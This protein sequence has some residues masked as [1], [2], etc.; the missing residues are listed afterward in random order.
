MQY[1]YNIFAKEMGFLCDEAV[2][3]QPFCLWF[4][5]SVDNITFRILETPGSNDQGIAFP[6]PDPFLHLSFDSAQAGDPVSTLDTDVICP[7][8]HFG[9]GELLS[10]PFF[11]EP[12][13]NGWRTIFINCIWTQFLIARFC[14]TYRFFH[15]TNF[16]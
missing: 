14:I 15:E 11:R 7:Q 4:Y 10:V 6:Y 13:T 3:S 2:S 9:K 12:Y 5:V 16:I 1:F 8:H